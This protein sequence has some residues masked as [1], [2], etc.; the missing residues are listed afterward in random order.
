MM[1]G[2]YRDIATGGFPYDD[3]W[4]WLY[5][6]FETLAPRGHFLQRVLCRYFYPNALE[7]WR[8]GLLYK[9]SGVHLFGKI[10][11]TGGVL[12]RRVTKAR[13]APYTLAGIS[14]ED[15]RA[16]YYRACVFETLHLPFLLTLLLLSVY[17]AAN[18]R[19]DLALEN[20]VVNLVANV[21][22]VM[23]HRRTRM[24]IVQLLNRGH[25]RGKKAGQRSTRFAS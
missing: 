25:A 8:G 22:P 4:G 23:H 16:F 18:G 2:E 6:T 10:I 11:P 3:G 24:R 9:L 21:Y 7:M 19:L 13:M 15:A 20:S 5:R 1:S 12:V 14:L 17:R